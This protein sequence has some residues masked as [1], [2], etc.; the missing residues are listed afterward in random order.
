MRHRIGRTARFGKRGAAVQIYLPAQQPLIDTVSRYDSALDALARVLIARVL[1][2]YL[3]CAC[4]WKP[5]SVWRH[6]TLMMRSCAAKHWSRQRLSSLS[7]SRSP[8]SK[9]KSPCARVFK[10]TRANLSCFS[11]RRMGL[12]ALQCRNHV[13]ASSPGQPEQFTGQ[14]SVCV[15]VATTRRATL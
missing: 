9:Q 4:R 1:S 8:T 6:W 5:S 3:V 14:M 13:A 10:T 2:R 11:G 7:R 12:L 15:C